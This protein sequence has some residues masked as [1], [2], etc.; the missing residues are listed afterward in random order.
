MRALSASYALYPITP[1]C[2]SSHPRFVCRRLQEAFEKS[3]LNTCAASTNKANKAVLPKAE[4]HEDKCA[5]CGEGAEP[6]KHLR[7]CTTPECCSAYHPQC[8]GLNK[9]ISV[10]SSWNTPNVRHTE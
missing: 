10:L 8:L 7:L 2:G 4:Q 9:R 1:G 3:P 6:S 5:V